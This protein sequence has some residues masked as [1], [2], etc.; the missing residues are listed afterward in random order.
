[1]FQ[2]VM[3]EIFNNLI[4]FVPLIFL[5]FLVN[6]S[7]KDRTIEHPEKGRVL[8][9]ISYTLVILGYSITFLIGMTLYLSAMFMDPSL[10][11]EISQAI[12]Q[13]PEPDV[14]PIDITPLVERLDLIGL[15]MWIPSLLAILIFIPPIHRALAKLIPY[16]PF[17]RVHIVSL[18]ISML[19]FLQLFATVGI[20]LDLLNQW[21]EVEPSSEAATLSFLWSQDLLM[22]LLS[23]IG[24]GWLTRRNWTESLQRLGLSKP[25]VQQL[26]ISLGIGVGLAGLLIVTEMV[27]APTGITINDQVEELTEQLLGPLFQSVLGI[28]TLGLAAAIGEE[29]IFRGALQPRF[30]LIFTSLLFCLL[31]ANYGFTFSTIVVFVIGLSLGWIR[32][33][34][35][36]TSSMIAHATYNISLSILGSWFLPS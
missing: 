10:W 32:N 14:V 34:Y 3:I 1:M 2:E 21:M 25:N 15:A 23:F 7:E 16:D 31:H 27:L 22:A 28:L 29:T 19:I 30:G 11:E 24:V 26:L 8:G 18:S 35:N 6:L 4:T 9:G 20:G 13:N 5:F 17:R 33:R 12:L 36:T